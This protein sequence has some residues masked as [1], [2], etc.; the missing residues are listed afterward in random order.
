MRRTLI[1][2]CLALLLTT[3]AVLAIDIFVRS[4]RQG[5]TV[6]GQVEVS[7]E[8]LSSEPITAVEIRLDGEVAARLTD[9]P[10]RTTVDMG[11]EN[12]AHTIEITAIDA[13]GAR[14][15][16]TV[17]TGMIPI[18]DKV[19][20]ELQQ[21]YVTATRSGDRVLDLEADQFTILDDSLRQKK[22]TFERGDVPLTAAILVDSSLSME[23]DAL[24][25]ALAGA[26]AFVE[27]MGPLDEAKVMVFSDRL[28]S[29]TPF[30]GDPTAVSAVMETVRPTGSTAIN[31]HL[32]LALQELDAR[33]GRRVIVLLSDGLDVDS[34]LDMAQVEW[35]AGRVQS[36]VYWIRP[37]SGADLDKKRASVWRDAQT[38]RQETEAL[39][40]TVT[41]SGGQVHVIEHIDSAAGAFQE[42]LREL[43]EQYV[44]GYYPSSNRN[45]GAWHRVE[46]QVDSPSVDIR[47]RGGYY[48]DE[49]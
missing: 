28:L 30:T 44:I 18:N 48:D 45:D 35:K 13:T 49:F 20:L 31:D 46:V 10:F 4:P 8:V 43:R 32:Y 19:E 41:S 24:E 38:Q 2:C 9:P 27:D 14:E 23:G 42:I 21:L 29:T 36:V 16:R 47:V 15:V 17:T 3:Q 34:V 5:E 25:S 22:V 33:Q 11:Q 6:F 1:I 7:V 40:H 26:R 39:Q 12:Q 37:S